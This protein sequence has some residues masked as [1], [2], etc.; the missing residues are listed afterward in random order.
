MPRPRFPR[1]ARRAAVPA[2]RRVAPRTSRPAVADG[3]ESLPPFEPGLA[4]QVPLILFSYDVARRQL[5]HCNRHCQTV[6]GY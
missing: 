1:L 3:N 5:L 2:P 4:D 6:L